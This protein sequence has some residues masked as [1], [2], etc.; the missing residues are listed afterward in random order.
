MQDQEI[1][2]SCCHRVIVSSYWRYC[3]FCGG[4]V[5]KR[6][7]QI[8]QPTYET[9]RVQSKSR[10]ALA[11]LLDADL[12]QVRDQF[13]DL[14]AELLNQMGELET[15]RRTIDDFELIMMDRPERPLE[16]TSGPELILMDPDADEE[17]PVRL[18]VVHETCGA[19]SIRGQ[20]KEKS[21]IRP[22]EN[23]ERKH[24]TGRHRYA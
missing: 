16:H 13:R 2:G 21:C 24:A 6:V 12:V 7:R 5:I 15:A 8:S 23:P 3:P 11:A 20:H 22:R 14:G 19:I 1:P 17:H 18:A 4:P 9:L 10:N